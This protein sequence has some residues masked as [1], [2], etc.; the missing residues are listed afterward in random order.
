MGNEFKQEVLGRPHGGRVWKRL[1]AQMVWLLIGLCH[2][3]AEGHGQGPG[4]NTSQPF[5]LLPME[6]RSTSNDPWRAAWG[7]A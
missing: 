3:L 5:H 2:L 4:L 6:I 7:D 1:R